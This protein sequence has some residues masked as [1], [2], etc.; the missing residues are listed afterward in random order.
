MGLDK[1]FKFWIDQLLKVFDL[2]KHIPIFK[3]VSLYHTFIF[4][5]V[6]GIFSSIIKFG[7]RFQNMIRWS[8]NQI[9]YYDDNN[10]HGYKSFGKYRR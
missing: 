9:T 7:I 10:P 4:L 1:V 5:L 3:D 8:D 6:L 2:M